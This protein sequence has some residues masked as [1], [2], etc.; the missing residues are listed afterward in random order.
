MKYFIFIFCILFLTSCSNDEDDNQ[1]GF[2]GTWEYSTHFEDNTQYFAYQCKR[3][4]IAFYA[5]NNSVQKDYVIGLNGNCEIFFV[6]N[7]NLEKI[8]DTEYKFGFIPVD[9]T[10]VWNESVKV[11]NDSLI[12][13]LTRS[14]DSWNFRQDKYIYLRKR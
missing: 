3:S 4:T 5:N 10:P 11:Q 8:N 7:S 2:V 1:V 13:D 9:N 6:N 12:I 14:E